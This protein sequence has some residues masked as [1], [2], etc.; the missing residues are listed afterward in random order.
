MNRPNSKRIN[1]IIALFPVINA[2]FCGLP[3]DEP[4][5]EETMMVS[6]KTVINSPASK[7]KKPGPKSLNFP[8]PSFIAPML[9]I[10][11]TKSKKIPMIV[12]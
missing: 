8:I 6:E 10:T 5:R 3:F 4:L 1:T 12:S 7:G 11:E 9:R 2:S